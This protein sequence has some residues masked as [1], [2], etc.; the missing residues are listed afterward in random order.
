MKLLLSIAAIASGSRP[1][2]KAAGGHWPAENAITVAIFNL[3][4]RIEYD[5]IQQ[6]RRNQH[7]LR[8]GGA[9]IGAAFLLSS[10]RGPPPPS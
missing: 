6:A 4:I 8:L 1:A 3:T 10:S 5:L 2:L 7:S 9:L